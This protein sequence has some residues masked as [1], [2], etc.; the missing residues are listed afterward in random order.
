M[1]FGIGKITRWQ[2]RKAF[3]IYTPVWRGWTITVPRPGKNAL[4]AT[5]DSFPQAVLTLLKLRFFQGKKKK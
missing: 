3:R 2:P 5:A 1:D 4:I